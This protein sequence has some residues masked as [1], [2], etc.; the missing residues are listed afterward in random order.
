MT[1]RALLSGVRDFESGKP[2]PWR[3]HLA[4]L[5]A[6]ACELYH[7]HAPCPVNA[8]TVPNIT[9]RL[10]EWASDRDARRVMSR[11]VFEWN[12]LHHTFAYESAWSSWRRPLILEVSWLLSLYLV[13][14]ETMADGECGYKAVFLHKEEGFL[15]YPVPHL[16]LA[17]LQAAI[18]HC[19]ML[20]EALC[21]HILLTGDLLETHLHLFHQVHFLHRV[22][23]EYV[24]RVWR[25]N[26]QS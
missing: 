13:Q 4:W 25:V 2:G 23:V 3:S 17:H 21:V 24:A 14:C 1:C 22:P 26:Q 12:L 11:R 6:T 15:T 9:H 5:L 18:A 16:N 20:Q 10:R 8:T 19:R 7:V